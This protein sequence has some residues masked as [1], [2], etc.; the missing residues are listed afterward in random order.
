MGT[1]GHDE[2][3]QS[4]QQ[5]DPDADSG[6]ERASGAFGFPGGA[7]ADALREKHHD[8]GE[9]ETDDDRG[10]EVERAQSFRSVVR[11]AEHADGHDGREQSGG[12][13]DTRHAIGGARRQGERAGCLGTRRQNK[14]GDAD[15]GAKNDLGRLG[16]DRED[17]SISSCASKIFSTSS[18]RSAGSGSLSR[19]KFTET[20]NLSRQT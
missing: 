8:P 7:G 14:F 2:T 3:A 9:V 12:D 6:P 11:S 17:D 1:A 4:H 10:H 13:H 15:L 16:L 5:H 20:C 18:R 19:R